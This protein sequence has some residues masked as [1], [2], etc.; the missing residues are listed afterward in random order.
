MSCSSKSS[1]QKGGEG[2]T[3]PPTRKQTSPAKNWFFTCNNYQEEHLNLIINSD[4]SVVPKYILEHEVGETGTP[5]LQGIVTFHK[6]CRPL[7]IF[8]STQFNWSKTK[9]EQA[10]YNYVTKDYLKHL[11]D[12][13][14]TRGYEIPYRVN[15]DLYDWQK[16]II[17]FLKEKPND[18][19]IRWVWE[20][21]GCSG[22]T[23]FAKYIFQT[24]EDVVVLS[25]KGSDMKHGVMNFLEKNN[26]HPKIVL[27]DMPRSSLDFISYTGIEEV[28]DMF[29][30]SGKYEGGM[31]CGASPHV[32]CFA[33]K[34]PPLNKLS[35]DRWEII[36]LPE[37]IEEP[38]E[39]QPITINALFC[40]SQAS[41]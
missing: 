2:N 12:L 39:H 31:V 38:D 18:R 14:W 6:K 25:G 35:K 1:G 28:K 30:Y 21:T 33:N 32:V 8:K 26:R 17:E 36:H 4:S 29:F 40:H 41:E 11:T 37:P 15:I 9:K 19:T 22:K 23:T 24:F 27:I 13:I 7:E 3:I 16:E 20:P 34:A 5:H 10:A